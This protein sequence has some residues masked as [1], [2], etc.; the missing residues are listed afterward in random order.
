VSKRGDGCSAFPPLK[1]M[2]TYIE[3]QKKKARQAII[4]NTR[5]IILIVGLFLITG[6]GNK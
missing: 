4:N 1:K 5:I 3:N 6:L 2:N